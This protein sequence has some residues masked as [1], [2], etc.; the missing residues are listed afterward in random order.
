MTFSPKVLL[1][2]AVRE[3]CLSNLKELPIFLK[4]TDQKVNASVLVPLCVVN[5]EVCLLYTIRS[6]NLKNHSGQI[7][8]PGGKMDKGETVCEAALRETE[9]EIGF[10]R[11]DVDV[12]GEMREVQGRNKAVVI[13]PVV[14]YLKNFSMER[15][16]ASE[17]EVS[18]IFTTPIRTLCNPQNHGHLLFENVITPVYLGGKHKIWGITGMITHLFLQ[19]LLPSNIY[20]TNFFQKRFELDDLLPSKL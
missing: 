3:K 17:E 14:G 16:R 1:S 13:L 5:D 11:N 9:E 6:L 20:N 8:F 18:D 4:D 12:W 2:A 15:L 10:P 7:A 19:S